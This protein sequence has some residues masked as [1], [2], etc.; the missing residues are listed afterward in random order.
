M[1]GRTYIHVYVSLL[2]GASL[3]IAFCLV[4]YL[5]GIWSAKTQKPQINPKRKAAKALSPPTQDRPLLED[6]YMHANTYHNL[7]VYIYTHLYI[8]VCI[9]IYI[10]IRISK[11]ATNNTACLGAYHRRYHVDTLLDGLYCMCICK[12]ILYTH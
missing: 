5:F 10:Y 2:I 9:Y 3:S 8:Y 7:C 12:T 6:V 11:R 1:H 4:I